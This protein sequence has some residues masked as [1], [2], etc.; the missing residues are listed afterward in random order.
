MSSFHLIVEDLEEDWEEH[1]FPVRQI[2]VGWFYSYVTEV[3][4]ASLSTVR[5]LL[6]VVTAKQSEEWE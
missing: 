4:V 2:I 6:G 1:F 5:I 3:L